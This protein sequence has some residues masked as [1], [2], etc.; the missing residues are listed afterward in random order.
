FDPNGVGWSSRN[1][2]SMSA[3]KSIISSRFLRT[4]SPVFSAS[5]R[6]SSGTLIGIL[7]RL[8]VDRSSSARRSRHEPRIVLDGFHALI[9]E[10]GIVYPNPLAGMTHKVEGECGVAEVFH[11]RKLRLER[12]RE[13]VRTWASVGRDE[14]EV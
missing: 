10:E 3:C 9:H 7:H 11:P 8:L 5:R 12:G 4:S 14:V 6:T 13:G 2:A 1:R